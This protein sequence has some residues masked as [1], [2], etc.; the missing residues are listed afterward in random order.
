M[1]LQA[2][3]QSVGLPTGTLSHW[4]W[5][6]RQ[7][8]QKHAPP[9]APT[10]RFVQVAVEPTRTEASIEAPKPGPVQPF[11]LVF[12]RGLVLRVPVLF[13]PLALRQLLQV[14]EASSC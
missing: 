14:L 3:A 6:L 2:F 5:R 13:D 11:E 9:T 7:R 12:P 4:R 1:T 10:P 8:D